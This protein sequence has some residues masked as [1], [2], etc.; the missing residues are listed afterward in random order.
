MVLRRIRESSLVIIFI[1]SAIVWILAIIVDSIMVMDK[2]SQNSE[3]HS[4]NHK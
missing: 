2:M 4:I 1:V 3:E